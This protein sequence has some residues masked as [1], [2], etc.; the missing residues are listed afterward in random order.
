MRAWGASP[1]ISINNA[2]RAEGATEV[3]GNRYGEKEPLFLARPLAI[4]QIALLSFLKILGLA[5]QALILP[6]FG[7]SDRSPA[8]TMSPA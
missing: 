8:F 1:R 4:L 3:R 5:P 6:A 7:A 2:T